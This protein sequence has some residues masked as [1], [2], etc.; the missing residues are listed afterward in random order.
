MASLSEEL[1]RMNIQST[2]IQ[3][4]KKGDCFN[5][6][7]SKFLCQITTMYL[8]NIYTDFIYHTGDIHQIIGNATGF[9]STYRYVY[10]E[11]EQS[12]VPETLMKILPN[13]VLCRFYIGKSTVM[14]ILLYG[15]I[16]N[17]GRHTNLYMI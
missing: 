7:P 4:I 8:C 11:T 16:P 2:N 13:R 3:S 12:H 1:A 10:M 6:T 15:L 14:D 5:S 9:L 17:D